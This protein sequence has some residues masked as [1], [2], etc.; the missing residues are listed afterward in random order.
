MRMAAIHDMGEAIV[1]D[2]TPY[3]GITKGFLTSS[4]SSRSTYRWTE[5]K[6]VREKLAIDFLAAQNQS[7]NPEFATEIRDLWKEYEERKT[8]E[9]RLV[10]DIDVF[11]RLLQAKGYEVRAHGKQD[12]GDFFW[13][14]ETLIET[15]EIKNW[16]IS[17]LY[18][19]DAFWSRTTAKSTIIFVLGTQRGSN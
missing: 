5:D 1:E 4:E 19:R 17:L 8:R 2:I 11:E 15:P 6:Y 14:W 9:A 16:T 12:L 7:T 3:D 18:E 10:H 13:Q